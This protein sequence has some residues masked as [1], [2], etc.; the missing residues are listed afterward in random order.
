MT[1][2]TVYPCG[3]VNAPH[4]PSGVLRSVEKCNKHKARQRRPET[5]ERAYYEE[6]GLLKGETPHVAQLVEALGVLPRARPDSHALEIG[7]G[8]S[9][10]VGALVEA[11]Y[12]PG[13]NYAGIDPSR[14]AAQWMQETYG[15]PVL[16][17]P[18]ESWW[19]TDFGRETIRPHWDLILAA[20]VIEHLADAPLALHKL[21]ERLSPNGELWLVVPDDS[22]PRNPD[23]LWFFDLTTLRLCLESAG[24]VV[25]RMAVRKYVKYENFIYCRARKP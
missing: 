5:L 1:D 8:A 21:A 13:Y 12:R 25:E 17:A 24:L 7:C 23:H 19:E 16:A 3:C 18:V 20:H 4:A 15:L 6:L 9:P 11:G 22:D 2:P 14:W 10:Y